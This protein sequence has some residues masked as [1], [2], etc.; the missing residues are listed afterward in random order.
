MPMCRVRSARIVDGGWRPASRRHDGPPATVFYIRHCSA[1]PN[2]SARYRLCNRRAGVDV[3]NRPRSL[4]CPGPSWY[5]ACTG[6]RA[7][8]EATD[9]PVPQTTAPQHGLTSSGTHDAALARTRDVAKVSSLIVPLFATTMFLSGFLLFLVEPMVAKMVLPILGGVP[10]VWNGCVVFFQI[11]MLAGYGYAFGASRWL[12]ACVITS[13]C[14][15][16]CSPLRPRAALH[17]PGGIGDGARRQPARMAAAAARRH[18]RP[19]VLRALDERVGAAALAVTDESSFGPRS[20]FPVFGEQPRLPAG[21][22]VLSDR[23]RT[24]VHAARADASLDHRL[25][26]SSS[27]WP[28]PVPSLPG[29]ET[30]QPHVLA[31][32]PTPAVELAGAPVTTWRRARWVALAFVPSSL[33]L[34][35]TSYMSTDIAAVPLLWIVPLAL[36]LL[37]FA[38]A[39]GR[40]SAAVGAVA[41][42]ALP[43]LVVAARAV[44]I[45][46]VRAPLARIVA[47]HLAAFARDRPQ[48]PRGSGEGPARALAPHRVLL[49]GIV[50]RDAR[51]TV[52]H[53]RR[54]VPVRQHR[55]VPARRAAGA[56]SCSARPTHGW[57]HRGAYVPTWSCRWSLAASTAGILV[58]MRLLPGGRS[59]LQ[60]AA[61]SVPALLTFT[62]RRHPIRF[63]ICMAALILASLAFGNA[64]ERVLY[65]TRTFFGVYRVSEDPA[66][67]LPRARARDDAARDA[68][69]GAGTPRRG[70]DLLP[71][72]RTVRPGVEGAAADGRRPR[73]CGRRTRRR[74]ARHLR[75]ARSSAGRSSKS[76]RRSSGSRGRP[77]I[78]R[79]WRPAAIA[80]AWSSATRACRSVACLQRAYD[81]LV[82]D[83][84]SSDSI[85]M[86]LMTRE[87]ISLYLSRLAPDGVLVMHISNRHLRLAP[88]V[89]R[90]AA[91]Q[92]LA[93]VQQIEPTAPGWPEGKNAVALDC[94]GPE[95]GRP[96]RPHDGWPVV[97]AR[98]VAV[99][100]ALD[101]RLFEHPQRAQH[102][103]TPGYSSTSARQARC[104]S[105]AQRV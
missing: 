78:S 14:T 6:A 66:G 34:A 102:S 62:Q 98:R 48:L 13:C 92:G 17:D 94:D 2:L 65:A 50:R 46:K 88:I 36:Y 43:L 8:M 57:S 20:V 81:L 96:R 59:A 47:L 40:H 52:Q 70:A 69:A 5:S 1:L 39:F 24:G 84:F 44:M 64:G 42:R 95:P 27:C 37:T 22:R 75:A 3:W 103:L 60:L 16:L 73:D 63:G 89:A 82:L 97:A 86:H 58:A 41:S 35:V 67:P 7:D 10:M 99:D 53:A 55:R 68:G 71:R 49:L 77:S 104:R 85:P 91:S 15:P 76:I 11:V 93:A 101:R 12:P 105:R 74:H 26:A 51:R 80:A 25:R 56:V 21:A 28:A 87:A 31:A 23:G 38:L 29:G 54:A 61:F 33:M 32:V 72:D 18:H 30:G 4:F 79:S 100:A 45:A 9:L 83:A 90:L 19:A